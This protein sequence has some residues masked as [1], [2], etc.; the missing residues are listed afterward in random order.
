MN[1]KKEHGIYSFLVLKVLLA[2]ATLESMQVLFHLANHHILRIEGNSE[3]LGLFYGNIIFGLAT[4]V[5]FLLPFLILNILPLKYRWQK[6]C[7]ILSQTL[8]ILAVALLIIPRAANTAYYQFTFRL[9][10]DEIFSYLGIGGQAGTLLPLFARDYWYAWIPPTLIFIL[11]LFINSRIHL[12]PPKTNLKYKFRTL[13]S[14]LTTTIAILIIWILFRGG[15]GRFIQP[16]DAAQFVQPKNTALVNNDSYNILRSLFTPELSHVNYMSDDEAEK[17]CPT[18]FTAA[19]KHLGEDTISIAPRNIVFIVVESLGQEFMGCYNHSQGADT[20]TP[21]LDSLAQHCSIYDGRANG[22]KSIEGITAINTSIPNL[23][24]QPFTNSVYDTNTYT[25]LPAILKRHGYATAFYHGTYN[26][27][28]D[29]D[30]I[31]SRIGFDQYLGKNEYTQAMC[32]TTGK[33][34][35]DDY[36]GAWGIFDEPFLQYTAQHLGTL[37][38]PFFAEIFTVTS[39]HPFPLPDQYKGTFREGSHPILKCVEYTDLAL[40]RFFQQASTQPW[41]QNTLFVIL[42]DHSGPGLTHQYYDY[43][44]SYRIPFLV[45][46]PNNPNHSRHQTIVQQIDLY[47][48]VLDYL[49]FTDTVVCFGHSILRDEPGWQVYFGNGYYCM[50]S[51]NPDDPSRHDITILAG[52]NEHGTIDNRQFLRA[53]IQQYNNRIINNKLVIR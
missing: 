27:V 43:D 48:T 31:C 26:G 44:G 45:Y 46:D 24:A 6:W 16:E 10:S 51:N 28:M 42:G 30:R 29:F 25:G 11:F 19:P 53:L 23:M 12:A 1:K 37:Q 35:T 7:R 40:R 4:V 8:Y 20:R 39:H 9:L 14:I 32:N 18:V 22:K 2:F 17:Y 50:V 41:F 52:E 38:E 13:H 47:P 3:W 49:G 21:F 33:P 36:D 34:H 5:T 15:V